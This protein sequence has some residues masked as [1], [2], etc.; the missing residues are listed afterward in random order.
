MHEFGH[1]CTGALALDDFPSIIFFGA[2]LFEGDAHIGT[3]FD[4]FFLRREGVFGVEV[5]SVEIA[6]IDLLLFRLAAYGIHDVWH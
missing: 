1:P 2:F 3:G 4:Y 5:G 6:H